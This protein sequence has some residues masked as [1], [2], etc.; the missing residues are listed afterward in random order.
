LGA[1]RAVPWLVRR[2]SRADAREAFLF[3]TALVALG[4]AWLAGLGGLSPALGAFI[5]G[6]TLARSELREQIAAEVLPLR[7]LFSSLFFVSIGTIVQR[8][9]VL[10]QPLLVFGGAAALVALKATAAIAALRLGGA[11][12]RVAA[13]AALGL[14]Q[15]GEFSFVL[16]RTAEGSDLMGP[17]GTPVF[18]A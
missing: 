13:A 6:L 4:G 8:D 16:G 18:A 9:V 1:Q 3:G 11:S 10:A 7:D 5:A 17:F 15:V 14:A 2:A 12:W